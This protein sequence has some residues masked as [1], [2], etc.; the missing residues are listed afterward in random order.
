MDLYCEWNKHHEEEAQPHFCCSGLFSCSLRSPDFI[1]EGRGAN[2]SHP[3]LKVRERRTPSATAT[4]RIR[5][6]KGLFAWF[7][8]RMDEL[9]FPFSIKF[10]TPFSTWCLRVL[11]RR[12]TSY[13]TSLGISMVI[14]VEYIKNNTYGSR[15][16]WNRLVSWLCLMWDGLPIFSWLTRDR[17]SC[18]RLNLSTSYSNNAQCTKYPRT[19]RPQK[20]PSRYCPWQ[21]LLKSIKN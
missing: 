19:K 14:E 1:Q 17:T 3:L 18:S 6:R 9:H 21:R 13:H 5:Q 10:A 8:W 15:S 7:L 4:N 16:C 11:G 20:M 12:R 2:N